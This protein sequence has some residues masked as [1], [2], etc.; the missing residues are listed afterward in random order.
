MEI[1][2]GNKG[3]TK[4]ELNSKVCFYHY[5]PKKIGRFK[6]TNL[7]WGRMD[8]FLEQHTSNFSVSIFERVKDYNVNE[9]LNAY[10]SGISL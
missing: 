3:F 5:F 10:L 8:Y 9:H 1:L 2:R 6:P 7:L 4:D